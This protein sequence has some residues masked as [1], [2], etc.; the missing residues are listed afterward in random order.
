LE[1]LAAARDGGRARDLAEVLEAHELVQA[2]AESW[3]PVARAMGVELDVAP[4]APGLLL[5]GDRLRLTQGL[6]NLVG[7]ALEHGASPVSLRARSGAAGSIRFEVDDAGAGLPAP[8]AE[9]AARPRAGR[10]RRGRGL[11]I[12]CDVARRHGGRV[13]TAP[14]PGGARVALELPL[15]GA[16]AHEAGPP[17]VANRRPWWRRTGE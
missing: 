15:L 1:D 11:S 5:R 13:A 17:P 7:N 10:G 16:A 3:R 8:V 4:V 12:A 14:S 9:L 2:V 6:G